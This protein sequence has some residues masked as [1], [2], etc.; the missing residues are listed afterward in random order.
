MSTPLTIIN[1]SFEST[2][3][4]DGNWSSGIFGWD[5]TTRRGSDAG[6]YNPDAAELDNSAVDGDNVAYLLKG[7][8]SSSEVS[9]SQTLSDTYTAGN[10]Y[11]FQ[12]DVGDGDYSPSGDVAYVINIYAGN[13]VIGTVSGSTGNIDT[14]QSVTVT[15]TVDD[16]ALNGQAIR[17]EIS[18]PSSS[19]SAELLID[20]VTGTVAP[21]HG[22]AC[23]RTKDRF[24]WPEPRGA[25]ALCASPPNCPPP[26]LLPS[27]HLRAASPKAR[28]NGRD[29][30]SLAAF[31]SGCHCTDRVNPGA[32]ST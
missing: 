30:G 25:Q 7:S 21:R 17:I 14:L 23:A 4:S 31:H 19:S 3:H 22:Y 1:G 5:I 8:R 18:I 12:L 29:T 6:D 28:N 10:I 16:A 13:T 20:N 27:R 2:T 9:I 26:D 11:E 32:P 15:S 24:W